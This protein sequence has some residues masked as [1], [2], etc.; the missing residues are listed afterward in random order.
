MKAMR[1]RLTSRLASTC[2]SMRVD[3]LRASDASPRKETD[4]AYRRTVPSRARV[5]PTEHMMRY[6]H[7]ASTEVARS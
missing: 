6:F 1:S 2:G 3:Q 5:M 7:A 4:D